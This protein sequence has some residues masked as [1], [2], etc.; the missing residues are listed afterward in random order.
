MWEY[1][2]SYCSDDELYHFGVK[3]MKW[4]VRKYADKNG[5]LNAEGKKRYGVDS[6]KDWKDKKK[7]MNRKKSEL[8]QKAKKKYKLD[9]YESAAKYEEYDNQE[10]RKRAK[11]FWGDEKYASESTRHK[12]NYEK[13]LSK[14]RKYVDDNMSKEYGQSYKTWRNNRET[15]EAIAVG[16]LVVTALGVAAVSAISSEMQFRNMESRVNNFRSAFNV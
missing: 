12:E 9:T 5:K 16:T 4:G 11:E 6:V 15:A 14:A 1:N 10:Q 7:E 13:Q 3:G 8:D 2:Y